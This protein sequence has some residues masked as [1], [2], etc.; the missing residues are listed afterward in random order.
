MYSPIPVLN[1]LK[2][3]YDSTRDYLADGFELYDYD[4]KGRFPQE[5]DDPEFLSRLIPFAQANGSGSTYA[6]WRSDDETDLALSP[7]VVF[8]DEGGEQVVARDFTDFLRL[9]GYDAEI[10]V[11]HDSAYYYREEDDDH[12]GSHEKFVEWLQERGLAPAEDPDAVVA[13]AQEVFR[14]RFRVWITPFYE[15]IGWA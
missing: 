11:D 3:L 7:V 9:L 5:L 1:E 13:A 12:S 14:E 10:M 6:I 2:D 15:R 8:G 4:D